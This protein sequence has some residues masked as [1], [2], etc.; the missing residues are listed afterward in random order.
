V[1]GVLL[2]VLVA[3]VVLAVIFAEPGYLM[4]GE[5]YTDD[6]A[7]SDASLFSECL[8]EP[9]CPVVIEDGRLRFDVPQPMSIANVL[10]DADPDASIRSIMLSALVFPGEQVPGVA[11]GPACGWGTGGITA[12]LFG[13]G[14]LQL[15]DANTA[16]PFAST[17]TPALAGAEAAQVELT[18]SQADP[19]G[20]VSVEARIVGQEDTSIEA[21]APANRALAGAG[22]AAQ[23]GDAAASVHFDDLE[24][25][26]E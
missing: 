3:L 25:A 10:L 6:F 9:S 1:L 13:D 21:T 20:E 7:S 16:E 11:G 14:T 18:C 24:V 22:F 12:Q 23:S 26:V 19:T 5:S 8:S 2:A 4:T 15:A 17:S